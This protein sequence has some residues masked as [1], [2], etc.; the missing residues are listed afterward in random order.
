MID[1]FG[2][3]GKLLAFP[4]DTDEVDKAIALL[5]TL[6]DKIINSGATVVARFDSGDPVSCIDQE[7]KEFARGLVNF[8]SE[9][10]GRMKGLKTLDIQQQI[11]PQE[12]EEVIHRDN[13]VIL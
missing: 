7:G 2:G 10:L 11:G 1:T 8:S 5:A 4:V 6:K 12:Y 9:L 3:P 13:L